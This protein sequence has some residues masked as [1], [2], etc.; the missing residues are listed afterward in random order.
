MLDEGRAKQRRRGV[1]ETS[2]RFVEADAMDLPFADE[3]FDVVA[4][5]FGLRN[6]ADPA[7][8]LAEMA[9]VCRPGGQVAVLEF[10]TPR[11]QPIRSL[12]R[13]YFR[14]VLPRLG[15]W[16]NRNAAAAYEYLPSSVDQFPAYED[17]AQLMRASG[18]IQ[19]RFRP[20]TMGI[21]TLYLGSKPDSGPG[22]T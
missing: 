16:F 4:V 5:A 1:P 6:I 8:G 14:R 13:F 10:T 11:R 18:L 12:Y 22:R 9:R 17:L 7:R 2:L 3:T 15:Q 20:L 19:V 21:A